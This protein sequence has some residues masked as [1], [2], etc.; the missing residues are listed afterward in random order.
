MSIKHAV[1]CKLCVVCKQVQ[2]ERYFMFT[3]TWDI[4]DAFSSLVVLLRVN[5]PPLIPMNHVY[6]F[7]S[8]LNP[9][10]VLMVKLKTTVCQGSGSSP[11]YFITE[12][13]LNLF[14][15]L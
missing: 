7:L 10:G 8:F 13:E 9:V 4:E 3:D 5:I 1:G 6:I 2:S 12:I 11:I 15:L 14:S